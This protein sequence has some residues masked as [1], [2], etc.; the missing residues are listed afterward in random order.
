MDMME[1]YNKDIRPVLN[2]SSTILLNVDFSLL[3]IIKMVSWNNLKALLLS[4]LIFNFLRM[5]I[6]NR[7][8]LVDG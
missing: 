8:L 6:N 5:I 7:S 3:Q 2:Y 4:K 1:G